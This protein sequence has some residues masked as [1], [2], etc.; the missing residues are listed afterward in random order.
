MLGLGELW[1]QV[2]NS[3]RLCISLPNLRKRIPER[4]RRVKFS[5]KSDTFTSKM[6]QSSAWKSNHLVLHAISSDIPLQ[7]LCSYLSIWRH[8]HLVI[9]VEVVKGEWEIDWSDTAPF[10]SIYPFPLNLPA[11]H[12]GTGP[13]A[14]QVCA[15]PS[16]LAIQTDNT[17]FFCTAAHIAVVDRL[18]QALGQR[19]SHLQ[20]CLHFLQVPCMLAAFWKI[21]HGVGLCSS[22]WYTNAAEKDVCWVGN[23]VGKSNGQLANMRFPSGII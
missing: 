7:L 17:G 9:M 16:N 5:H 19:K 2:R 11:R 20:M 10:A 23:K 21:R 12:E 22:Q 3:P 14:T 15:A 6:S 18:G 8:Q 1:R 4:Y 13:A